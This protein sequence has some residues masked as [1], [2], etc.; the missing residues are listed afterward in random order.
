MESLP[1]VDVGGRSPLPPWPRSLPHDE[2]SFKAVLDSYSVP[3]SYKQRFLDANAFLVYYTKGF[4][5]PGRANIENPS[6]L[7][8]LHAQ[9]YG[10]RNEAWLAAE[11]AW[12]EYDFLSRATEDEETTDLLVAIQNINDALNKYLN[13]VPPDDME[14]A[15]KRIIGG[16]KAQL[17]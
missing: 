2:R 15:V 11:T 14:A 17:N 12:A 7:E 1:R 13:L 8:A 4:D 3:V 5:G 6:A 10:F 16:E 9:Q